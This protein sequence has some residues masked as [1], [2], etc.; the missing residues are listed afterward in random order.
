MFAIDEE[1]LPP[2]KPASAAHPIRTHSCVPCA[3]EASQPLGTR[4]ASRA[5]GISSS[6]ALNVVHARPPYFGTANVYGMRK[7]EPT[8]FGTAV[9]RNSSP[10]DMT[11]PMFARLM[12]TIV[13]STHTLK[14]RFSAK[15]EKMRFLRAIF[16]APDSQTASSSGSHFSIHRPRVNS[17]VGISG[18]APTAPAGSVVVLIC[19]PRLC[20]SC[21]PARTG[22]RSRERQMSAR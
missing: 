1:K 10:I 5:V 17:R 13:H 19:P 6:V 15:I 8:R 7:N 21:Q 12:T 11:M 18:G 2:P 22:F 4:N 20:S 3:C 14:P 16:L 9:S